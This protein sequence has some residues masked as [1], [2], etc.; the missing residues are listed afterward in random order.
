ML[1]YQ[2]GQPLKD[3]QDDKYIWSQLIC[4]LFESHMLSHTKKSEHIHL[5]QMPRDWISAH[6]PQR[7][8]LQ[9]QKYLY[10]ISSTD[11]YLLV[12]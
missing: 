7:V 4:G 12:I 9:K 3:L 5:S 10:T 2:E 11:K 8:L 1:Q 6:M